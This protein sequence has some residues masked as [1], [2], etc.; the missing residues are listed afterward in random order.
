MKLKQLKLRN[1]RCYKDETAIDFENLTAFVGKND[2]GKSSIMDALDIFLNDEMPDKDDASVDGS[3]NDLTI[4]CEFENC[5]DEMILDDKVM[6]KTE[7]E[8]ILNENGN[9][10]IS[11][12]YS[13]GN[14]KPKC[15]GIYLHALH[16]TADGVDDLLQLKNTQLKERARSR[17]IDISDIDTKINSQIRKRI[18]DKYD[19]LNINTVSIQIDSDN[20]KQLWNSIKTLVPAFALFKSDRT[21]T[22]QDP[23]AQDPLKSAIKEAIKNKEKEL[24]DLSEYVRQ[25]V[26][27]IAEQTLQKIKEMDPELATELKPQIGKPNWANIFKASITGDENIPI[28]KRGSGVKRLI[29]LNFFRA[30][31]DIQLQESGRYSVIYGI[32][33]PETS[34][35]PRN[36]RL[37]LR[38]LQDLSTNSQVVITTHTPMLARALPDYALRYV[39]VNESKKRNILYGGKETNK[40]FAEDLGVLPDNT[41]Q[42]FIG[43]EG[44]HD[45]AFLQTISKALSNSQ[46]EIT[47]PELEKLELEGKII[48]IPLGGSSLALWTSRLAKLERTEFYLFDRD[49]QPPQKGRYQDQADKINQRNN[50][51]AL[52]TNKKEIENYLHPDAIKEAYSDYNIYIELPN[53]IDDF[54]NV[55]LIVAKAVHSVSESSLKWDQLDSE[56]QKKKIS[57]VKQIL[58]HQAA[59]KMNVERL[60]E[61]SAKEEVFEWFRII[62]ETLGEL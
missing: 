57:N 13:G 54:D 16:P 53:Q 7:D 3:P 20:T 14:A 17:D 9:L 21:S 59:S 27:K 34:Q 33:E 2:S 49:N 25:E 51:V 26:A 35:H 30:K 58:N 28:N 60:K 12:T 18:R 8:Y 11:K 23:E 48:F 55:P 1:F 44:A 45:I 37:L 19:D 29:L 6:V 61:I 22:D 52:I 24:N 56:K 41:I 42:L 47:I 39:N 10:E 40:I 62:S 36:Q 50:C 31:A 5:P 4:S 46:E 43:V 32:E 38:A 15:T